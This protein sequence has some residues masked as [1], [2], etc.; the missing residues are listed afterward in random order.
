MRFRARMRRVWRGASRRFRPARCSTLL[1]RAFAPTLADQCTER[2]RK[3]SVAA[4]PPPLLLPCTVTL[5]YTRLARA[6]F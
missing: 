3:V 6:R 5:P 1:V 4:L 2:V